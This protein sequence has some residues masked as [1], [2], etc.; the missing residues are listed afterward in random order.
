VG[1]GKWI[2]RD[3]NHGHIFTQLLINTSMKDC[4]SV[5]SADL[6]Y[7]KKRAGSHEWW[8]FC[9]VLNKVSLCAHASYQMRSLLPGRDQL[10]LDLSA[11]NWLAVLTARTCVLVWNHLLT[12]QA[13]SCHSI[14][15]SQF[16]DIRLYPGG[17][18]FSGRN[19]TWVFP[20][21]TMGSFCQHLE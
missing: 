10:C 16:L 6:R 2:Y 9:K 3:G 21:A 13:A 15:S 4:A 14:T 7:N 5:N 17:G 12:P 20:I 8:E 19:N 1:N 18:V 11:S